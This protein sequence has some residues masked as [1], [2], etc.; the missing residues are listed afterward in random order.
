MA[1]A[2]GDIADQTRTVTG[3]SAAPP[4]NGWYFNLH[5]GD[6]E[7]ILAHGMPTLNFRP[8]LCANITS[9]QIAGHR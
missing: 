7:T 6:S 4:S 1:N 5:L 9:V 2:S 8:E 3:V